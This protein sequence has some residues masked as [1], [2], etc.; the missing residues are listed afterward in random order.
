MTDREDR[1][2]SEDARIV[3]PDGYCRQLE[4]YLCRKNDGH[5]IRIVG[6]TFEMVCGWARR[7]IPIQVAFKGVDRY[8][9]R[10]RQWEAGR[11]RPVRVEFCEAD[12]LDVFDE[13][14]RA[15]GISRGIAPA[16][17]NGD[18]PGPSAPPPRPRIG[19]VAHIDR[20]M[21]RL[22]QRRLEPD[23]TDAFAERLD[24]T[25]R[26]LD[27]LRAHAQHARGEARQQ[28]L[29]RLHELDVELVTAARARLDVARLRQLEEEAGVELA[30]FA[31]RM[32]PD[33]YAE[34]RVAALNRL[35]R[36][37]ERLPDIALRP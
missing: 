30:P 19:L 32:P 1:E 13:W 20:V 37:V 29:A 4:D 25:L 36:V 24:A 11:R 34:A 2:Q 3:A 26:E 17:A 9:E 31:A 14:R 8:F 10:H 23:V 15:V 22:T 35:I 27:R 5:L 7:G 28:T 12:I 21:A 6:P 18:A 33:A 16:E